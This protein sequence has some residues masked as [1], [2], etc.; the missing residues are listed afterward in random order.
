M[1]DFIDTMI[2]KIKEHDRNARVFERQRIEFLQ[3]ELDF[4]LSGR[5]SDETAQGIGR[6]IGADTVIYGVLTCLP[7]GLIPVKPTELHLKLTTVAA[8]HQ[9]CRW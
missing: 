8:L 5:V 6:F 3:K 7:D 1:L 9:P 4:S 2:T